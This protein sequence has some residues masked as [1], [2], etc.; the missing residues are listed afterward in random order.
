LPDITGVPSGTESLPAAV[1][2][3]TPAGTA[4]VCETGGG[5]WRGGL[6]E[7]VCACAATQQSASSDASIATR[8]DMDDKRFT[9]VSR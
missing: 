3:S 7:D 4:L 1:P 6:A 2:V 9:T 8:H 5:N